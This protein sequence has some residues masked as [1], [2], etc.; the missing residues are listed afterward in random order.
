M[1]PRTSASPSERCRTS[2]G[3]WW[4]ASSQNSR[5]DESWYWEYWFKREHSPDLA[6]V[7]ARRLRSL[8][9]WLIGG[10]RWSLTD[11]KTGDVGDAGSTEVGRR[12]DTNAMPSKQ[13][14]AAYPDQNGDTEIT[15]A[16]MVQRR[17][18]TDEAAAWHGIDMI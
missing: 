9:R 11:V 10:L 15:L 8:F 6:F 14:S 3:S 13:L 2:I 12:W 1:T 4:Q 5:P 18:Q 7:I 17:N 16:R